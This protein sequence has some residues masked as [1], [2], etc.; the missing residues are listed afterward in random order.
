MWHDVTI[1]QLQVYHLCF[2]VHITFVTLLAL[3]FR[4]S[5][6]QFFFTTKTYFSRLNLYTHFRSLH[7]R[8]STL[9]CPEKLFISVGQMLAYELEKYYHTRRIRFCFFGQSK[10]ERV[11]YGGRAEISYDVCCFFYLKVTRSL[12]TERIKHKKQNY[13]PDVELN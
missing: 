13:R 10:I 9:S 2:R 6:F 7:D 12:R 3:V 5:N 8:P 11:S 4:M 1:S